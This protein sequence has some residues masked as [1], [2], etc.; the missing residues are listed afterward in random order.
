[1]AW[2][3]QP[4]MMAAPGRCPRCRACGCL[5][6]HR[7]KRVVADQLPCGL[8]A[9][10][11]SF[12]WG[13]FCPHLRVCVCG[14]QG[15]VCWQGFLSLFT[16][17]WVERVCLPAELASFSLGSVPIHVCVGCKVLSTGRAAC[18]LQ[19][20]AC[21]IFVGSFCPHLCFFKVFPAGRAGVWVARFYPPAGLLQGPRRP[22]LHVSGAAG[23]RRH[24]EQWRGGRLSAC[25]LSSAACS[26]SPVLLALLRW[27]VLPDRHGG[28][29]LPRPDGLSGQRVVLL[30]LL[31]GRPVMGLLMGG[32]GCI[33]GCMYKER[34]EPYGLWQ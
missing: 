6:A 13:L 9:V 25:L 22:H 4:G 12:S 14:L 2:P 27:T 19:G 30:C 24:V 20:S 28:G 10:L 3:P 21:V 1:L 8:Q 23:S 32:V 7:A 15:F 31:M 5:T 11:A 29:G 16:C 33:R 26:C 34:P 17:V 18:G